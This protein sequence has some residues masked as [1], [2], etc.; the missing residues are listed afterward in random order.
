M[1]RVL[2]E[3]AARSLLLGGAVWLLIEICRVRSLA[4]RKAAWTL[5]LIA[6]LAMPVLMRWKSIPFEP[7]RLMPAKTMSISRSIP[8]IVQIRSSPVALQAQRTFYTP[9][10]LRVALSLYGIAGA[11]LVV[12]L[13]A[14][15]TRAA[16]IWRTAEP[17]EVGS[18][19]YP[20]RVSMA[21]ATPATIGS[22]ILLPAGYQ[23]WSP[24]TLEMVL[25]HEEAHVRH[26]DYY[27]QLAAGVHACIFW[28][29]PL[30]WWLRKELAALAEAISDE[31]ALQCAPDRPTYAELLLQFAANGRKAVGVTM[32]R[33]R[34]IRWRVERILSGFPM[35]ATVTWRSAVAITAAVVPL[36][37]LAAFLSFK[38]NAAQIAVD[39][40]A[41]PVKEKVERKTFTNTNHWNSDEESFVIV[42]G[43][44]VTMSGSSGDEAR[45]RS[46]QSRIHGDYLWFTRDGKSYFVENPELVKRARE[47]FKPQEELGAKQAALGEQQAKLGEQQARLGEKQAEVTVTAPDLEG[48][49]AELHE[50]LK[51]LKTE[52]KQEL[53]QDDLSEL[54]SKLGELQSELGEAQSRAGAKQSDLGQEQSKL[55]EEQA[56]LG[57]EQ[58]KLGQEQARLAEEATRKLNDIIDG[59]LR[60][61]KAKR[62]EWN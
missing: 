45:A 9:T 13:L 22:G 17:V 54:Q 35:S 44:S 8:A 33:P 11:I 19:Q 59:V 48:R 50:R 20:V 28:F 6:A 56:K 4:S 3:S 29:N 36:V 26:G 21:A 1:L 30:S 27:V 62:V 46:L 55:G 57:E 16:R 39:K 52:R 43:D 18:G 24:E 12:R 5:A 49:I 34:N 60:S 7:S 25:A 42:S 58:S 47:L 10:W 40:F 15:V 23:Q 37:A 31:F 53:K 2:L 38:T 61:G 14:R 32:A 41:R 51:Q